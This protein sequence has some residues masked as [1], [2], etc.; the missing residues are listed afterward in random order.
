VKLEDDLGAGTTG[1]VVAKDSL[2]RLGRI[3]VGRLPERVGGDLVGVAIFGHH[4]HDGH[5]TR[6]NVGEQ[7]RR[8]LDQRAAAL[9]R[10]RQRRHGGIEVA[11][12]HVD[13]DDGGAR[14]IQADHERETHSTAPGQNASL[15]RH[16]HRL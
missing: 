12:V 2:P 11:A 1:Q 14:R 16:A 9:G 15:G 4:V 13:G 5:A 10:E 7:R 8:A 6:S 3:V